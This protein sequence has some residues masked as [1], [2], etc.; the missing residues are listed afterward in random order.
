MSVASEQ[1]QRLLAKEIVGDNL[2]VELGAFT[3]KQDKGGES[4]EVIREVPFA[5][6]LNMIRKVADMVERHR[7]Y[8]AAQFELETA[9]CAQYPPSNPGHVVLLVCVFVVV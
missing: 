4:G 6:A 5:Y 2:V 8:M 3:V 9:A 7:G 1:K